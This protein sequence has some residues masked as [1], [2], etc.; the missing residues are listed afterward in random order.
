MSP[1]AGGFTPR[2]PASGSWELHPQT[3]KTAPLIANFC[4]RTCSS[5]FHYTQT[6]Q[7]TPFM[8]LHSLPIHFPN[9]CK[10]SM[11]NKNASPLMK[12][13]LKTTLNLHPIVQDHNPL[14]PILFYVNFN[15]SQPIP[16]TYKKIN[17]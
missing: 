2:P 5:S 16:K 14:Y 7:K 17:V 11:P 3:P 9:M 13:S 6:K 8:W 15:N 1:A 4:L 12:F 10:L